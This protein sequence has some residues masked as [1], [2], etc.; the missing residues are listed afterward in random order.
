MDAAMA[1]IHRA[2]GESIE[3][4]EAVDALVTYLRARAS[5]T[6]SD[7]QFV[8]GAGLPAVLR[9]IQRG[10]DSIEAPE[11]SFMPPPKW[12]FARTVGEVR[13]QGA[14]FGNC[15]HG[16]WMGASHWFQ[17][18]EGS[19][20]FLWREGPPLLLSMRALGAGQFAIDDLEGPDND[21]APQNVRMAVEDEFRAAGIHMLAVDPRRALAHL[22][23][24]SGVPDDDMDDVVGAMEAAIDAMCLTGEPPLNHADAGV[25]P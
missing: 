18:V 10:L 15:L 5:I 4:A 2:F 17:L 20:S 25:T 16:R 12:K 11:P 9:R 3:T 1:P 24:R 19:K 7:L 22:S 6:D 13:E 21:P 14:K 23:D 8:K